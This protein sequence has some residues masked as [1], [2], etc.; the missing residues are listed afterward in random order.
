MEVG[1]SEGGC[2]TCS[3]SWHGLH[4]SRVCLPKFGAGPGQHG[5]EVGR[6]EMAAD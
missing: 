1:S 3:C 5:W 6:E 2:P 4:L